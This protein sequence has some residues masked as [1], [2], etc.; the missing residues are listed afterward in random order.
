MHMK[1]NKRSCIFRKKHYV[2]HQWQILSLLI[3][4]LIWGCKSLVGGDDLEVPHC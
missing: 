2:K 3:R 1:E 4:A